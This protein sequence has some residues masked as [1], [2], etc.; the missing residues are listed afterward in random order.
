MQ[1]SQKPSSRQQKTKVEVHLSVGPKI[2]TTRHTEDSFRL[3]PIH[4][5]LVKIQLEKT[6]QKKPLVQ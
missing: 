2:Y 6:K 3:K 1:L 5:R 4:I